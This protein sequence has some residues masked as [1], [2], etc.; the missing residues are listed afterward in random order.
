[1]TVG[2]ADKTD[3]GLAPGVFLHGIIAKRAQAR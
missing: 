3:A 2:S 1:M